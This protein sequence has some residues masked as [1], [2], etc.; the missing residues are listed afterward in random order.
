MVPNA[1]IETVS[2]PYRAAG[3]FAWHFASAKLRHDPFFAHVLAHGLI[4]DGAR[5]LDLGSG[6]GLLAAWLFGAHAWHRHEGGA[7]PAHWPAPAEPSSIHGIE[8]TR[9]DV[10][11]ARIAL[12]AHEA[13]VRFVCDVLHYVDAH[14]QAAI[15]HRV[16]ANLA[17]DGMLLLRVSDAAAGW[18]A[19]LD[20]AVDF[21]MQIA[22]SGR[23]SGLTVRSEAQ[24][25]KL[26]GE[27]R[28]DVTI[29]PMG[30]GTHHAN[31]LL[32]ARPAR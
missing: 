4:P 29:R 7:W 22:R 23:T 20:R 5:I 14:A 30:N 6:Q 28:F 17:V 10:D 3:R 13:R 2:R 16:R 18:R 12:R 21:G 24:W 9:R 31:R 25:L 27:L 19:H 32:I 11:R 26:L 8:L 15:L 1:L